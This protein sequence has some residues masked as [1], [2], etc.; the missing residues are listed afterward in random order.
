MRAAPYDD[1]T[2]RSP[3]THQPHD[4][5]TIRARRAML[6]TALGH[7]ELSITIARAA[8]RASDNG[9][10]WCNDDGGHLPLRRSTHKMM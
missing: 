6:A 3:A 9:P 10:V 8:R 1:D 7:V 4:S 5:L 2:L